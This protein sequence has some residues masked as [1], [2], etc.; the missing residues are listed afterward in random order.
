MRQYQQDDIPSLTETKLSSF[1]ST[2]FHSISI[3]IMLLSFFHHL[4]RPH[5]R[6]LTMF[7]PESRLPNWEPSLRSSWSSSCSSWSRSWLRW[8]CRSWP[9]QLCPRLALLERTLPECWPWSTLFKERTS[10]LSTPARSKFQR[11]WERRRPELWEEPCPSRTLPDWLSE[12]E[13]EEPLSQR[14]FTP[15][16]PK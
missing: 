6:I 11:T 15:S 2:P 1:S 5:Q 12:R 10:E 9:S 3:L 8:R 14:E 16:R 4:H 13:R 7:R